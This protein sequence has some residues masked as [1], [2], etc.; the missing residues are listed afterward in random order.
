MSTSAIRYS[1][2]YTVDDY[3]QWKGDWELWNGV[4]VC[5][6]PA[7]TPL[8]QY[9]GS[10]LVSEIRDQLR[11]D[12]KCKCLVVPEIDWRIDRTTVVRPD[13]LVLCDGLPSKYLTAA[14]ALIAEILS[15]STSHKDR[16]AKRELY[17][18]QGVKWYL[19]VAPEQKTIQALE[20]VDGVYVE[21]STESEEITFTV[22]QG[23]DVHLKLERIFPK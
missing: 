10:I 9:V 8:H 2:T 15:P 21:R 1:P 19:L 7:P 5:M 22:E 4:A 11:K 18:Q 16:T 14:P 3:E 6:S 23:C 17:Q 12:E 20:L 13:V